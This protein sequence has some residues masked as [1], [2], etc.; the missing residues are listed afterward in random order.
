MAFST[1]RFTSRTT[2]ASNARSAL[3]LHALHDAL[4]R[5]GR[6]V[7]AAIDRFQDAGRR[8]HH[9]LDGESGRLP[10]LVGD[11]GVERIGRGHRQHAA[12]DADR[13]H[14]IL[15]QILGRDVLEHGDGGRHLFAPEIGQVLLQRE[16]A[17]HVVLGHGAERDESLADELAR[18]LRARER[19]LDDVGGRE[20]LLDEDFA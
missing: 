12:L 14:A 10:Q 20:A 15:A 19:A 3:V 11:D 18:G 13:D 1:R 8:A 2:G 7:V 17:Q 6:A 4:Q 5:R 9:Q 16:C